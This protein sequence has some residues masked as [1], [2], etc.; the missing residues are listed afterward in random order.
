MTLSPGMHRTR[1]RG[2]ALVAALGLLI[3]AAALLGAT[4]VASTALRRA[5]I[6]RVAAARAGGEARRAAGEAVRG[7]GGAA[8]SLAVGATLDAALPA[9]PGAGLP[10]SAHARIRRLATD[11]YSLTVTVRV[12]PGA[13]GLAYRRVDLLLGR[14]AIGDSVGEASVAPLAR[15]SIVNRQ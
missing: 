3:L 7:W 11:F 10:A 1:R 9:H 15:W 6:G 12:G 2:V 5:T 14:P 8:D 13:R 4:V